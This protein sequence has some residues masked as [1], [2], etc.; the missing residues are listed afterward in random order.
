[1]T[2]PL[3]RAQS[4]YVDAT[5][6]PT[7][8]FYKWLQSVE[9]D[10]GGTDPA[11]A[12]AIRQIAEKLGSP[13]GSVAGIPNVYP[14]LSEDTSIIGIGGQIQVSGT[15]ASGEALVGLASVPDSGAGELLAI[16]RDDFGRVS[17]SRSALPSDIPNPSW[18]FLVD[19]A[20]NYL[21]DPA[22]DLLRAPGYEF[23]EDVEVVGTLTATRVLGVALADVAGLQTALDGT[24]KTTGAQT[25]AGIKTWTGRQLIQN[26]AAGGSQ[27]IGCDL[28]AGT[29]TPSVV[30]LARITTPTYDA[31]SNPVLVFGCQNDASL[32]RVY[33]GGVPGGS[34]FSTAATRITF[35]TAAAQNT[36]GGTIRW[37][38]DNSGHMIPGANNAYDIGTSALNAR[39]TYSTAYHSGASQVV[40]ARRTGWAAATGT[41]TRTSFATGTVTTAQLAE[42]VKALLDD[43][44]AH[45]L[46]GA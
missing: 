26:S 22:G 44:I 46:I 13:D 3:P 39:A 4:T 23:D 21:T 1:M 27:V 25:A 18:R 15:L 31:V 32:N 14:G 2:L 33:F 9:R 12:L 20:G 45:G 7:T 8:E 6:R 37:E 30:K 10:S 43:L 34:S 11:L 42:R 17:G 36:A 41:A 24:V 38:V 28:G 19:P 29:I 40:G 16:T 5:G 35:M